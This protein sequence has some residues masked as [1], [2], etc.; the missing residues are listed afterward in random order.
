MKH[1]ILSPEYEAAFVDTTR[2]PPSTP[3]LLRGL[4]AAL[5]EVKSDWRPAVSELVASLRTLTDPMP[6]VSAG[7]AFGAAKQIES[8]YPGPSILL[9]GAAINAL[10]TAPNV[11]LRSEIEKAKD[12]LRAAG[13]IDLEPIRAV[14]KAAFERASFD[15]VTEML[16]RE[17]EEGLRASGQYPEARIASMVPQIVNATHDARHRAILGRWVW[18]ENQIVEAQHTFSDD[19]GDT[20]DTL[21]SEMPEERILHYGIERLSPLVAAART[22]CA[23]A[24]AKRLSPLRITSAK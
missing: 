16:K 18:S 5:Q 11:A 13:L 21:F 1:T 20:I 3:F 15:K 4:A 23:H 22:G 8:V 12:I 19:H 10:G 17:F 2:Y 6:L 24:I 7:S 14:I 9:Y